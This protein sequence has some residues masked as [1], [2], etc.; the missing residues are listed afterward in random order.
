VRAREHAGLDVVVSKIAK[1]G[2]YQVRTCDAT[3]MEALVIASVAP[4]AVVAG[5][6][7]QPLT[8]SNERHV[9]LGFLVD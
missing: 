7:R 4:V 6:V 5:C 3:S 2:C 1:R 9:V 8:I